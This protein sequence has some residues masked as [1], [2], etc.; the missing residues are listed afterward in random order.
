MRSRR[1]FIG[2]LGAAASAA[3]VGSVAVRSVSAGVVRRSVLRSWCA[4]VHPQFRVH[5]PYFADRVWTYAANPT[6]FVRTVWD[7]ADEVFR[8]SAEDV[9]AA[10]AAG[11]Q[12]P[13]FSRLAAWA[14]LVPKSR[15][16]AVPSESEWVGAR[17]Y[18][19]A[20]PKCG[21]R[22]VATSAWDGPDFDPDDQTIADVSCG[23]CWDASRGQKRC[24]VR[25]LVRIDGTLFAAV[26][27]LRI[28]RVAE[29]CGCAVWYAVVPIAAFWV[30]VGPDR[31]PLPDQLC[32]VFEGGGFSGLALAASDD[33]VMA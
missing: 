6:S 26:D 21:D 14:E 5:V 24:P 17:P 19:F 3:A 27:V 28:G 12:V 31:R 8:P 13:D 4:G 7:P 20:C 23:W 25:S 9:A 11:V 22:R 33:G 18:W 15:R 16:F 2:L 32:L 29:V 30:G 10:G 1:E